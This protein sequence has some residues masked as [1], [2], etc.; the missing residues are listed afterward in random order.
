MSATATQGQGERHFLFLQG[1]SSP[2]FR[3]IGARLAG[4]GHK[5]SRIN[6]CAGGWVFWH[7]PPTTNYRGRL[8]DWPRFVEDFCTRHSVTDVVLLGEERP[9]HKVV[10]SICDRLGIEVCVVE[11]GYLRPDWL[12]LERGGMSTNS[13]FPNDPQQIMSAA[14]GLPDPDFR[15][16][17]T[18]QFRV[19]ALLDLAYNLPNIFFWF[20][21]PHYR[22]YAIDHPLAEYAGW[23]RKLLS[24][25]H[26]RL[27]GQRVIDR[28]LGSK[29]PFFLFPLQLETDYQI[30][31]HSPFAS[32]HE[33]LDRIMDA[34]AMGAPRDCQLL[35]KAHPLDNCLRNWAASCAETAARF[36]LAHRVHFLEQGDL[37][38]LL[39]AAQGVVTINST[40]GLHALLAGRPVKVLGT[41]LFDIA[42]LTDQQS[43]QRFFR[44]P[45]LPDADLRDAFMRLLAATIQLR[46]NFYSR[47]GSDAGAEAIAERLSRRLVNQPG[48]FVPVPPRKAAALRLNP[49][50]PKVVYLSR[51]KVNND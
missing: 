34:F 13:H 28:L 16:K 14:T 37:G 33:V 19:V 1:P 21:Y 6:I 26:A 22:P 18:Q 40:V 41:A 15:Q 27:R 50:Q 9:H 31:A 3:K 8:A 23:A 51:N 2:I 30:R 38:Q 32:Q 39:D 43:L 25:G 46:G 35:V 20:L 44:Q 42:G 48:A 4:R 11:M 5:V 10:V 24:V 29:A 17:Y 49:A 36:G 47:I 12:T 45:S 7:G